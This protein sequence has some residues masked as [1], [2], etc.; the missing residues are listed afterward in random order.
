MSF[1]VGKLIPPFGY[2][3]RLIKFLGLVFLWIILGTV[4]LLY[5]FHIIF[6]VT[7]SLPDWTRL[8][9]FKVFYAGSRDF[10][11]SGSLY[12]SS[13]VPL[14]YDRQPDLNNLSPP[15]A[16]LFLPFSLLPFRL[17]AA[18]WIVFSLALLYWGI[19]FFWRVFPL[20]AEWHWR[21]VLLLFVFISFP[22]GDTLQLGT[23]GLVIAFLD[24]GAWY[25]ARR[26]ANKRAGI[27][28]GLAINLRWQPALL[29]LFFLVTRRWKVVGTSILVVF[30]SCL[31]ALPIF[32]FRAYFEFAALAFN[33]VGRSAS[34]AYDG[35]LRT[36]IF[37]VFQIVSGLGFNLESFLDISWLISAFV[38]AG[39]TLYRCRKLDFDYGFSLCL[40]SGMFLAPLSWMHYHVALLLPLVVLIT[41]HKLWA[42][43]FT[44]LL[45]LSLNLFFPLDFG[46]NPL[47]F[48]L[49][50]NFSLIFLF[51][52]LFR[53]PSKRFSSVRI[54]C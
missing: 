45:W 53:G 54:V 22:V 41:H 20:P 51:L 35:S 30:G 40:V 4:F 27:L 18:L 12:H 24:F 32:G 17:G 2:K 43:Y 1:K 52:A 9:D 42:V 15:G 48:G 25:Y 19:S 31:F 26:G 38:L 11:F 49:L 3:I 8:Y 5:T 6:W 10:L 28:L 47:F 36:F 37:R 34:N 23:W 50:L 7:L 16:L 39:I 46:S 13:S 14:P 21:A 29:F 33:N 44:T